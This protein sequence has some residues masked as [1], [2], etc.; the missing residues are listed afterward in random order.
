[1]QNYDAALELAR[2]CASQARISTS[3]EAAAELWRM[4]EEYQEQAARLNGGKW[5]EIGK[6][7]LWVRGDASGK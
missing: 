6:P 3:K 5:P 4:A 2:V 7:P 1:M